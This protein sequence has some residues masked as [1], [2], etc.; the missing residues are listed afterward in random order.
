MSDKFLGRADSIIFTGRVPSLA[1][2]VCGLFVYFSK[3]V[4]GC[5]NRASVEPTTLNLYDQSGQFGPSDVTLTGP[6]GVVRG[7]MV[8]TASASVL[9][10]QYDGFTFIATGGATAYGP[11]GM[12]R[13]RSANSSGPTLHQARRRK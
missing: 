13:P 12:H 6:N 3:L 10:G 5:H 8:L 11:A 2:K 9:Q 4:S 7:S 1:N